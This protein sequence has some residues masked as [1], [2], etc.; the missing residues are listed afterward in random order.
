MREQL[1]KK[2]ILGTR[3]GYVIR[4]TCPACTTENIIINKTPRDHFKESRDANCQKCRKRFA[5][6]TPHITHKEGA[7]TV[8][9][10]G[11]ETNP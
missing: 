5:I 11:S 3:T 4:F 10:D 1:K 7:Y 9:A 6:L 2:G 8:P